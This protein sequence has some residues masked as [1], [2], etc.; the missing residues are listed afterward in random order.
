MERFFKPR[1]IGMDLDCGASERN[2]MDL[3]VNAVILLQC[4]EDMIQDT[5]LRPAVSTRVNRV[6]ITGSLR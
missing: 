1:P 4:S 3:N 2:M 6:P 5:P